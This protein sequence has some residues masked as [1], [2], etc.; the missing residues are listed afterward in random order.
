MHGQDSK[1]FT[2]CVRIDFDDICET[3]GNITQGRIATLDVA[4]P[5]GMSRHVLKNT[6]NTEY[7]H[8]GL[9]GAIKSRPYM[10]CRPSSP[11]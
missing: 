1:G 10:K 2:A 7:V 5:F 9:M 11:Q 8:Y 6:T 3:R 4:M